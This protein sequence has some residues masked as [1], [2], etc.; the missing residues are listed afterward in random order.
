[1]ILLRGTTMRKSK[2]IRIDKYK[3]IRRIDKASYNIAPVII[4]RLPLFD[5]FSP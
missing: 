2:V 3:N 5:N 4:P 1:M